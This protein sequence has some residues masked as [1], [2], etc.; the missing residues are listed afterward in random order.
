V[1]AERYDGE[2][3]NIFAV[4]DAIMERVVQA[5][6]LHLTDTEQKHRDERP[7]TTSLEAYDLVLQARKLMTRFDH[8][9]AA[10][11][12]DLLQR[13]IEIDPAYTD[14]YS[15][16]GLYYF[17]E[18]RLWGRNRDKNLARA[19]DLAKSAVELN[20]SDPAPHVLLAQVH[21][22]RREFDAASR[23]ADEA[24][25]LGPNDAITLGNL[26]SML[27][28]AHRGEEALDVLQQAVRLDPFHPA[29]YLEWLAD[30][31]W[32]VGDSVQC[33]EMAERGVALDPNF[34]ALHVNLAQCYAALGREEEARA[35]TA[36]ILRIVPRFTL[37]AYA[38][39]VPYTD[40]RDLQLS[41]DL[42]RKAGVPESA[43]EVF[44]K[45]EGH[46]TGEEIRAA[47][48]G[49]TFVD[50]RP[51]RFAGT[52]NTFDPSGTMNGRPQAGS[53]AE[54]FGSDQG[55]WWIED[56]KFCRK[57]TRWQ[58]G[59]TGCFSFVPD[60]DS[61]TWINRYGQFHSEMKKLD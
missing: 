26:G 15:L 22:F 59:R 14:A 60:G 56:D 18:W 54:Q 16:L 13:A 5:L 9:A 2:L 30:S 24:L 38:A 27:R 44:R 23:E 42:L 3:D 35:A 43:D 52:L 25:S 4:Q 36:E 8:K 46:M 45:P 12:R 20:P 33:V 37:K 29:S 55:K 50:T 39:Y 11:A 48:S 61:I 40:D 7:K 57:W 53:P 58:S 31:Y 49:Q 19:L 47:I 21:Q 17:D 10:E 28:W 41:V 6:E 32:L 1:W 51:V 34:V